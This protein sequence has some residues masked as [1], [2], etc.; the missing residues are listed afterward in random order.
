[1]LPV[2]VGKFVLIQHQ[3]YAHS[4]QFQRANQMLKMR[5][6]HLACGIRDI[7]RKIEATADSK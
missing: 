7:V 2:R 5:G 6:P 1:M 3:R 4:R